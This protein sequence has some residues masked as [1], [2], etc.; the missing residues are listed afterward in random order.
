MEETK[1]YEI[2]LKG[3]Q[4]VYRDLEG[5]LQETVVML[6]GRQ[7]KESVGEFI[8]DCHEV[9]SIKSGKAIAKIPHE[10]ALQYV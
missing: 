5:N 8:E 6:D 3:K 10:V 2:K 9:L 1:V 7:T 4:V